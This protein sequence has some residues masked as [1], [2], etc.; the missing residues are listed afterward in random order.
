MAGIAAAQAK[1]KTPAPKKPA[2]KAPAKPTACPVC[3]MPLSATKSKANPVAVK[4][5]KGAKTLY[6]CA[7]CKMPAAVLVKGK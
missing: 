5:K 4:L 6:C 3:H 1:P 7:G 2:V